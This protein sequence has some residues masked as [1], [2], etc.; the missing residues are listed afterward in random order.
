[1]F[2]GEP[3]SRRP[4]RWAHRMQEGP[5]GERILKAAVHRD[6]LDDRRDVRVER[7]P[8]DA[9]GAGTIANMVRK[10]DRAT[11]IPSLKPLSERAGTVGPYQGILVEVAIDDRPIAVGAGMDLASPGIP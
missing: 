10:G 4:V 11:G 6:D 2:L 5:V 7:V 3:V 1:M 9:A 8:I